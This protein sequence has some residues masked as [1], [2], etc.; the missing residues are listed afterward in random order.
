[1]IISSYCNLRLT[2]QTMDLQH[3]TKKYNISSFIQN[4]PSLHLV[5]LYAKRQTIFL[6]CDLYSGISTFKRHFNSRD[7]SSRGPN[8]CPGKINGHPY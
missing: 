3:L 2:K 5:S 6:L 7:T 4:K 8:F 1:M